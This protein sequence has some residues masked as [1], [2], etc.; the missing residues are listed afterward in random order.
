MAKVKY[1]QS[2]IGSL[3]FKSCE[4]A[5]GLDSRFARG[6]TYFNKGLV[7]NLKF[8]N[9]GATAKVKGTYGS[10]S[11]NFGF[12]DFEIKTKII[13]Y[14]KNNL[15]E[16]SHLLNG[17]VSE[18]F[19]KWCEE[20]EI[21]LFIKKEDY[22]RGLRF[23]SNINYEASCSCYDFYDENYPCKHVLALLIGLSVEIDA[24]PMTLFKLHNID[25]S[26]ILQIQSEKPVVEY[27]IDLR[28]VKNFTPK[29]QFETAILHFE[30]KSD[31]ILSLMG[32]TAFA[33]I[34]YKEV[35][36]EFY[37]KSST[38]L[39]QI[40]TPVFNEEIEKI[41]RVFQESR[42]EVTVEHTMQ[43]M[44]AY[45][46]NESFEYESVRQLMEPFIRTRGIAI[47]GIFTI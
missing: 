41:R 6:K 47:I 40:I 25:L 43:D 17:N 9:G 19:L 44:A 24:D 8:Q 3:W 1:G 14:Y 30:N 27:P 33:P 36:Q 37:K 12:V 16:Q 42:I 4:K 32:E 18:A 31:F 28:L 10:Y 23:R 29:Q 2:P 46:H 39:P 35:M 34:D 45:I 20:N 15:Y 5:F 11:V 13:E 21:D 7:K 26:D 38:E 22:V